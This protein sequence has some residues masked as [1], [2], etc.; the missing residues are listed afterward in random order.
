MSYKPLKL[1]FDKELAELLSE[2]LLSIRSDFN[3]ISFIKKV[4]TGVDGLE[5]KDRVELIA[6]ELKNHLEDDYPEQVVVLLQILGPEN[7]EETGMFKEYYWIMPIAKF[8]EKYGLD[9]FDTSMRAIEE[10]TKRNTGEYAIRPFIEKYSEQTMARM[11]TWSVDSNKHIR[12]LSSE[13]GRPR[14]PWATKLQMFID[15]PN[16]LF[17]ILENLK[18]DPSKYVQKSVA[19]CLNDILKDNPEV[20]KKII[21]KWSTDATKERIW[22]IKHALRNLRK[23]NDEWAMKIVS[24]L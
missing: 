20:A 13:G 15:G 22:I 1:W 12:R 3:S 21:E 6:D 17:P 18:D 9:H 10:I 2:K 16:P 4:D 23:Q 5:L 7:D 24:G 11:E 8:V 19:N 14:L